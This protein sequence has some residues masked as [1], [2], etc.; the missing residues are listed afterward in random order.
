M[1]GLQRCSFCQRPG[2]EA[3]RLIAGPNG[4]FI[5]DEC[6]HL[7]QE[8]LDEST[9]DESSPGEEFRIERVPPPREILAELNQ[10]VVGQEQAKRVL[11]VAVYNHYKRVNAGGTVADVEL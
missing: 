5:C 1:I 2:D 11:S 8:I 10:Y 4:V 9:P 6:I 3:N 7:C